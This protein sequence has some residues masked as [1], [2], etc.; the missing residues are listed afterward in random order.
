MYT[1]FLLGLTPE[2]TNSYFKKNELTEAFPLMRLFVGK[3]LKP[4]EMSYIGRAI[5]Y[6]S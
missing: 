1:A 3:S 6:S 5:S 4:T 2:Q